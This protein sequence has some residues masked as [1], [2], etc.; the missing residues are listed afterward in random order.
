MEGRSQEFILSFQII[1]TMIDNIKGIG[2]GFYTRFLRGNKHAD[3]CTSNISDNSIDTA[4]MTSAEGI[5]K[6]DT[7]NINWIIWTNRK[8][9]FDVFWFKTW[10]DGVQISN[11][12]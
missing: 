8:R 7:C 12:S 1:R 5:S 3:S 2:H 10:P 11:A 6:D 9:L 4:R